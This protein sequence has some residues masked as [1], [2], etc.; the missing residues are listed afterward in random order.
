M[1][2]GLSSAISWREGDSGGAQENCTHVCVSWVSSRPSQDGKI[3]LRESNI[4]KHDEDV[5]SYSLV[6]SSTFSIEY[7]CSGWLLLSFGLLSSFT[8]LLTSSPPLFSPPLFFSSSLPLLLS[9]LLLS[10]SLPLLP[11]SSLPIFYSSSC[12]SG[13]HYAAD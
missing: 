10:S 3:I 2:S 8:P 11:S 7:S 1:I 12:L 6:L 13:L 4:D 5:D 9:S